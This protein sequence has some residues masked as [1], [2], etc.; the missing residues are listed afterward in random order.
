MGTEYISMMRYQIRCSPNLVASLGSELVA[1][2]DNP[3]DEHDLAMSRK[4]FQRF[5]LA[6]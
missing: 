2:Q 3:L 6:G 5:V 4:C 1:A